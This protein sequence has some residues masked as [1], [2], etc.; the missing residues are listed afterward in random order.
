M[1]RQV[2]FVVGTFITVL[3]LVCTGTVAQWNPVSVEPEEDQFGVGFEGD[4]PETY[5]PNEFVYTLR[6]QATS[7]VHVA[8]SID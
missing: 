8:V 2:F 1:E 7:T 6:N 3:F 4:G 5:E